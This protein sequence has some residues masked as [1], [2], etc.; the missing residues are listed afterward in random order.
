[1]AQAMG[2]QGLWVVRVPPKIDLKNCEKI[3]RNTRKI[4]MSYGHI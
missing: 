4:N 2:Y 3:M 1:M